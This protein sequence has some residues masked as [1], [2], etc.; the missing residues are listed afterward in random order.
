MLPLR[1]SQEQKVYWPAFPPVLLSMRQ[2][3]LQNVQKTK[4]N[5]LS[6][7]CR[8]QESATSPLVY[9]MQNRF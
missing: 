9:L 2:H 4:G 6:S 8:I 7:C 5:K 1:N 3:S